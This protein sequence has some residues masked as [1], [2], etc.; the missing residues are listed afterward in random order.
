[1]YVSQALWLLSLCYSEEK[2]SQEMKRWTID[3]SLLEVLEKAI[4]FSL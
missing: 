3:N 1:M 4:E 2:L